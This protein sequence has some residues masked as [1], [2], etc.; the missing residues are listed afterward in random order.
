MERHMHNNLKTYFLLHCHELVFVEDLLLLFFILV[1]CPDMDQNWKPC[2]IFL[3]LQRM[4]N[5]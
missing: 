1:N 2:D 4:V 3:R 5:T